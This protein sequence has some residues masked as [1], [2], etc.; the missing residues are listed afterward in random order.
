[1]SVMDDLIFVSTSEHTGREDY[2]K[3]K[4]IHSLYD[5]ICR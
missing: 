5:F 4:V 1:M 2:L 3:S